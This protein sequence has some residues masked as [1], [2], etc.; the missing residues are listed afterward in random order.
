MRSFG[1]VSCVVP[2]R[3]RSS[4]AACS[5]SA[6]TEPAVHRV[7]RK[8]HELRGR[9]ATTRD[10]PG[11]RGAGGYGVVATGRPF[12]RT[13]R[14]GAAQP[15][16]AASGR[17]RNPQ[18]ASTGIF[19][20]LNQSTPG[21]FVACGKRQPAIGPAVRDPDAWD[22]RWPRNLGVQHC[23]LRGYWKRPESTRT[24]RCAWIGND[25]ALPACRGS[26]GGTRSP[27]A[28]PRRPTRIT[29]STGASPFSGARRFPRAPDYAIRGARITNPAH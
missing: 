13:H 6:W 21:V 15:A 12:W 11:V 3:L 23:A 22:E 7:R 9:Q 2:R 14:S 10:A 29:Q 8:R 20:E 19:S 5:R 1:S 18:A 4:A 16:R 25:H 17:C 28:T 26:T 27:S 24:P